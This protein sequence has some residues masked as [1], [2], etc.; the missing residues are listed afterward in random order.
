MRVGKAALQYFE[1]FDAQIFRSG[2]KCGEF[3]QRIQILQIIARD[4][5]P[6]D[7]TIEI[8]EVADHAGAVVDRVR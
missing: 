2:H 6:F 7:K 1:D 4:H 8:D 5:F 3:L